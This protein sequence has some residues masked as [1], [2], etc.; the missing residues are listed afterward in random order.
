MEYVREAA[1]LNRISDKFELLGAFGT[2]IT[3]M[4]MM[5]TTMASRTNGGHWIKHN[6]NGFV[7][8]QRVSSVF[9]PCWLWMLRFQTNKQLFLY[10]LPLLVSHRLYCTVLCCTETD[11]NKCVVQMYLCMFQCLVTEGVRVSTIR[12]RSIIHYLRFVALVMSPI[13]RNHHHQNGC[14]MLRCCCWCYYC[15]RCFAPLHFLIIFVL[16]MLTN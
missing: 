7:T 8:Y 16:D 11:F 5:T 2:N 13:H 14:P 3:S 12:R 10:L 9:F 4:M 15:S 1:T 6:V